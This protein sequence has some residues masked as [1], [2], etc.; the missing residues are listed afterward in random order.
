MKRPKMSDARLRHKVLDLCAVANDL[1]DMISE[2]ASEAKDPKRA[3]LLAARAHEIALEAVGPLIFGRV[4][5][6]NNTGR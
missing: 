1:G 2:L 6:D 3:L 4:F 5:Q